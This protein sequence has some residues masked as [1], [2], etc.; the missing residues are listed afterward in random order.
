MKSFFIKK[1]KKKIEKVILLLYPFEINN[2]N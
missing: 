2:K 1:I